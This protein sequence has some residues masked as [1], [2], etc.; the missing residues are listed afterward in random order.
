MVAGVE[1]LKTIYE[2]KWS[3]DKCVTVEINL[4]I[5]AKAVA[6]IVW[7]RG[8]VANIGARLPRTMMVI[9]L[10]RLAMQMG[11]YGVVIALTLSFTALGGKLLFTLLHQEMSEMATD[12]I[13][14]NLPKGVETASLRPT[15]K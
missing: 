11:L 14:L 7:P 1:R 2:D 3:P 10:R 6:S 4:D 8:L 15:L 9:S 13:Q 12:V 5:L